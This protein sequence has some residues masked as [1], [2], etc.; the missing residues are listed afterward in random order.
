M[1][2]EATKEIRKPPLGLRPRWNH[3]GCRLLEILD[4]MERYNE[5]EVN[6]PEEWNL[7][8]RSLINSPYVRREDLQKVH[9]NIE[10]ME[11]QVRNQLK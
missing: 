6:W 2:K 10:R 3:E 8:L 9:A 7:E 4:A 11:Q 5:A 1:N